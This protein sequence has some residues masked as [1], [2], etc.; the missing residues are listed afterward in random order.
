M[1][2]WLSFVIPCTHV[3]PIRDGCFQ[4]VGGTGEV[5]WSSDR[6][7]SLRGSHDAT[8]TVRTAHWM[9]D[10]THV[11]VSGNLVKFFQGHNLFGTD[12]VHG[13]VWEFMRW[14]ALTH[15]SDAAAP[16]VYPTVADVQDW[17]SGRYTLTRI[18][19][20]DSYKLP[21]RSDVLAWLR[22]AEETAHLAHRGRGQLV[23]GSTLYFGK[24]SRRWSLKLYAKGQEIEEHA[25][26]QPALE[27]LPHARAW[28]DN[29]L[30]AE[31]VIRSMQLKDWGLSLGTAWLPHDGLPFDPMQFLRDRLGS[32]TM[33]TTRTLTDEVLA[34]LSAAQRTAY[35]AWVSG[36]D[37]RGVMPHRSFY[38]LRA[39]LLPHG[40]DIATLQPSEDRSNVVPLVRVLE[41][42]PAGVPD[43]AM[44]TP[45]YFE[46]RRVA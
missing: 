7:L 18:D 13:L 43:W 29:V 22:A 20:T 30:R 19:C 37:L 26:E 34:S 15:G 9:G 44:D 28:A 11:E 27:N 10:C 21:T 39:K 38:R 14:F 24:T 4:K 16:M 35:L 23:K 25:N 1:I 31:L 5:E 33:T 32:M 8:V 17:K 45:L 6:R 40:V 41:A 42:I 3:D 46:P 36:V 12:D 2:D